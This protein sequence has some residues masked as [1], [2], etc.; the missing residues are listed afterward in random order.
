MIEQPKRFTRVPA[1]Q[2]SLEDVNERDQFQDLFD[3]SIG[4]ERFVFSLPDE[5]MVTVL[6]LRIMG[7][8]RDEILKDMHMGQQ[9]YYDVMHS[10]QKKF[11][12]WQLRE[13]GRIS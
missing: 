8:K 3:D 5:R 13:E 10:L 6:V 2:V 1:E 7:F 11:I 12:V 9:T 4:I